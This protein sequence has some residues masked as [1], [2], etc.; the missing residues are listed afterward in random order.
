MDFIKEITDFIF[1]NDAP[2]ESDIIF[3]PGGSYPELGEHAAVSHFML[4]D[5]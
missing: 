4:V 2:E 5:L 1:L 3:I